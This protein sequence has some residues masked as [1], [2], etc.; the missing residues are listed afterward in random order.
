MPTESF[1]IAD[2]QDSDWNGGTSGGRVKS[3]PFDSA[4]AVQVIDGI[5][6]AL[7]EA[8]WAETVTTKATGQI[9]MNYGAPVAE[10]PLIPVTPEPIADGRPFVTINGK[11]MIFYNPFT[12]FP[13]GSTNPNNVFVPMA[14][15]VEG[16]LA[17]L[18]TKITAETEFDGIEAYVDMDGHWIMGLEAKIGGT[19]YN[20][21]EFA[22]GISVFVGRPFWSTTTPAVG[23]GYVIRSTRGDGEWLEVWMYASDYQGF[24]A[25]QF[26]TST[27]GSEPIFYL[28]HERYSVSRRQRV[29]KP[30][31]YSVIA[32]QFQFFVF[33]EGGPSGVSGNDLSS[34]LFAS[35]PWTY[36]EVQF[37]AVIWSNISQRKSMEP[38]DNAGWAVA[39]DGGLTARMTTNFEGCYPALYLLASPSYELTDSQRRPILTT[40]YIGIPAGPATTAAGEARIVGYL[41]DACLSSRAE[42]VDTPMVLRG[43]K[44]QCALRQVGTLGSLHGSLFLR[45]E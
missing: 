4:R 20:N 42:L 23:G 25:F 36:P 19:T 24:A 40:A 27:G 31:W 1:Q 41:W 9:I 26:R 45:Y 13:S 10:Q 5:R 30:Y 12:Q 33:R 37:A 43:G 7:L 38:R 28:A 2:S 14:S 34:N 32:N 39:R 3:G 35:M 44:Y 6:L 8:G 22:G 16:S 17:A 18:R 15:D 29:R 21:A 11:R